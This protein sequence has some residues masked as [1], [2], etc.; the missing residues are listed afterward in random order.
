MFKVLRFSNDDVIARPS[1]VIA[2]I[3][4][5]SRRGD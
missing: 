5:A 2:A 4:A 1:D 3:L